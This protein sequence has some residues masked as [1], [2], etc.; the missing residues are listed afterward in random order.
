MRGACVQSCF[1][2][3]CGDVPIGVEER[4]NHGPCGD[5]GKT[6]HVIIQNVQLHWFKK[7]IICF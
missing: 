4:V 5:F 1:E 2:I 3:N 6:N 7:G